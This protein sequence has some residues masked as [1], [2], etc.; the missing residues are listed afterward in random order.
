MTTNQQNVKDFMVKA[1][2]STPEKPTVPPIKDRILRVRLLMEEVLELAEA[3]GVEINLRYKKFPISMDTLDFEHNLC[4][5]DLEG[6]ADALC[7]IN[8]VNE[9][10]GVT[11]GLDLE[12]FQSEVHRS[13]MSKFIDGH[14][15][16]KTGKWIKGPSYS[17]AD[18]EPILKNQMKGQENDTKP[19]P[20]DSSR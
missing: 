8:Y 16:E 2:Q 4:D 9:G 12:P 19:Y 10:A 15:D 6:I 17:P 7:D 11:Y 14:R 1:G 3:S 18:L 5:P 20:Y 13:N